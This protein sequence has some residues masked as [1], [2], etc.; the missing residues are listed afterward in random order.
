M[1]TSHLITVCVGF[2]LGQ[3]AYASATCNVAVSK[4]WAKT[5]V[6]IEAF[7][8]G[9]DC[10]R[11][12]VALV[13]R[14]AKGM[15][16]YHFMAK[17]EDVG[18]FTS[19]AP[20]PVTNV[21]K[22]RAAL[23]DWLLAAGNSKQDRLGSFPKWKVGADGPAT[24][25]PAEFPFTVNSGVSREDYSKWQKDNLPVFCFVQGIESQNCLIL[26][27]DGVVKEVGIQSFPG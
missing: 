18:I 19:L 27:R 16:L 10:A 22:M 4:P 1:R 25:P 3:L 2:W 17:A 9:P 8:N 23:N 13:V 5:S 11:A 15:A 14:D 24:M 26:T 20:A 7:S 21:P 6:H 12:V